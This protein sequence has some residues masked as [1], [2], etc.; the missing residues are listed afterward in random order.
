MT[1][2]I[3]SWSIQQIHA[4]YAIYG[5]QLDEYKGIA[6]RFEIKLP[7]KPKPG[8]LVTYANGSQEFMGRF[9][10]SVKRINDQIQ[11]LDHE[12]ARRNNLVGVM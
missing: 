10:F 8:E 6:D 12:I 7:L 9:Y 5:K 3:K 2:N 1:T 11:I 4:M